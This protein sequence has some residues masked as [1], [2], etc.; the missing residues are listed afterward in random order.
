MR[1]AAAMPALRP[2]ASGFAGLG[3]QRKRYETARLPF[4]STS[5]VG[6]V[7]E[8]LSMLVEQP[9]LDVEKGMTDLLDAAQ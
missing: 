2:Y 3:P 1:A 8:A 5:N 6:D 9:M 7:V 4:A